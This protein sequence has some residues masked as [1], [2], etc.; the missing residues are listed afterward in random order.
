MQ[1]D[2]TSHKRTMFPRV[3]G[4]VGGELIGVELNHPHPL[5]L[6]RGCLG[7]APWRPSHREINHIITKM[8]NE[9]RLHLHKFNIDQC[10]KLE[11]GYLAYLFVEKGGNE[12]EKVLFLFNYSGT[13]KHVIILRQ[14]A[15]FVVL[16]KST[17]F[18]I[19]RDI[20]PLSNDKI[21]AKFP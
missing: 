11:C 6:T 10:A 8:V 20:V 12:G 7:V 15:K 17:E 19:H 4:S 3:H 14:S 16:H 13:D 18:H 2:L 21:F 9:N 1:E 5:L